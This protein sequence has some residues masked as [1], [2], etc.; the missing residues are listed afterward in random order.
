[1][2]SEEAQKKAFNLMM[3]PVKSGLDPENADDDIKAAYSKLPSYTLPPYSLK[4]EIDGVKAAAEKTLAGGG[5][6]SELISLLK[7]L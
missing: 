2:L 3:L 7:P 4:S 6:K 5:N 1:M